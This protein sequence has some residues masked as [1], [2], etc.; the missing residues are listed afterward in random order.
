MDSPSPHADSGPPTGAKP[1]TSLF[2]AGVRRTIFF[3]L[4]FTINL[5]AGIWL[6][7]LYD[8]LGLH[9][10]HGLI[11]G[12][13]LLL[14]GLL[15]LGTMHAFIG[16]WDF[17]R[18]RRRAICITDLA[19]SQTGP[20]TQKHVVVMPVYNEDIVKVCGRV[21]AIYRSIEA[22]GQL[23]AFDFYI[24]SDTT[25]LNCWVEEEVAWTNMC[26][27]LDGFGKI[28]YRRRR[29]N[30]NRKAG[31]IGDFVRNWGGHYEAMVV[32][33]ADSLMDGGDIVKL[34]RTM[35]L[36]PRLGIL[37][38]PPKL[39][40]GG[41]V[42]TR[43]QQFAM[44]LYGPLFIRGLN[45]WQL[46][47]GSYWG[48]NAIIRV[49]PFSE[50]CELPALPGREPFGG[51]ILSHDFVEAALMVREGWEVWLAW[52]I[53]GTYEEAPPTL[54]DHLKRDRR[55]C[56]GNLQHMWLVFARKFPLPSRV[57][58]FMGIMA[59]LGSP[60]WFLFL[61][62]GTYVAWDRHKSGL[63]DLPVVSRFVEWLDKL[64]TWVSQWPSLQPVSTELRH[65][66]DLALKMAPN[67]Q[68]LILMGLVVVMLF[69]PK[70]L[71]LIGAVLHGPTRRSFGG[72]IPLILG[73]FMEMVLSMFMAP[74]IM[75]AHT[76]M[77]L[78]M[79]MGASV[80]WGNQTRETDGTG[81]GEA[82]SVH[83]PAFIAGV[84]WTALA[85][86][87]GPSFALWMSPILIGMLLSI[88]MSVLT[89]RVRYGQALK[90]KKLF[91]IPEEISPP[92]IM[93]LADQAQAAVDAALTAKAP[94]REGVIAA[95]VDPYVNGVHVSLLD[96][97]DPD[98]DHA[99]LAEKMLKEGAAALKKDELANILYHGPSVLAMHRAVWSRPFDALHSSWGKAVESYRIRTEPDA[100]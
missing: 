90:S 98:E 24:L 54:V 17:I 3:G 20:L 89:S 12:L 91:S 58:L 9:K 2:T 42:F 15:T 52:D 36:Y 27:R 4:V 82:V 11:L 26:R 88:P 40:R 23:D 85:L 75:I 32:L 14:N 72:A 76:F 48:H 64:A 53:V 70:I 55:W 60:L 81:W 94:G 47:S 13:F 92:E 56:Q 87:I 46:N 57:H 97:S 66:R 71:A 63:S 93:T 30:E 96:A 16:V 100:V 6:F 49:R 84:A 19:K 39:I 10:A 80:S 7:D 25:D 59:Y 33:D 28:Y 74:A 29:K 41:S 43:M 62:F 83:G 99:E 21:E 50:F 18:G 77:I 35:E 34:A 86:W 95:V 37:Q 51:R 8:R 22:A 61:L 79:V 44:R 45:Y 78:G 65:L 5:V 1:Y 31:N 68:A 67:D 69:L 38:T 73:V